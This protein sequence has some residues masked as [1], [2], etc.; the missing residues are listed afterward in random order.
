MQDWGKTVRHTGDAR[1]P[2]YEPARIVGVVLEHH[3]PT[4]SLHP[5]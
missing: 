2:L 3:G 1:S 5:L 4:V